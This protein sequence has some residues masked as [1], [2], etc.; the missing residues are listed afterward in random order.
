MSALTGFSGPEVKVPAGEV[1]AA[2]A[3]CPAGSRAVSGGGD[4]GISDIAISEMFGT[5]EGWAIVTANETS[6]TVTIQ[7]TVE[8]AGAG[9]AVAASVSRAAHA[10]AER[11]VDQLVA[12]L[13]EEQQASER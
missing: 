2:Y 11:H 7:A 13:T 10:R 9:Q 3:Y 1:G 6:I 8:C 12:K 4:G 5:H